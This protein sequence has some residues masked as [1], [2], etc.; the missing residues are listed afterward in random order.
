MTGK[1]P[2]DPFDLP[3]SDDL[4]DMIAAPLSEV[5]RDMG[6]LPTTNHS[7]VDAEA[8]G[9]NREH[10]YKEA[11]PKCRGTGRWYSY[12]GMT[13]QCFACK[14]EGFKYFK[15]SAEERARV[16][17][18]VEARKLSKV[19]KAVEAFKAEHPDIWAWMDGNTFEFAV[20]MAD[21]VRK[22]GS[23]TPGQLDACRRSIAKRA[24]AKAAAAAR[25]EN[26]P[27][28][29]LTKLSLA[30]ESARS[31]GLKRI[32]V[33]FAGLE[34]TEAP[35]HGKN[36]GSLYV[37]ADGE[38]VGKI[39]SGRFLCTRECNDATKERVLASMADPKAAAIA[40][41]KETGSCSCCG[42]ELSNPESIALG[43]GP[44]CAG[45]FGWA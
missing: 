17:A 1:N 9:V 10:A 21:A 8:Y 30:F 7:K 16:R 12:S 35:A 33:R 45:K 13:G 6:R 32:K 43:I 41:G 27:T 20:K 22:W 5:P 36:A 19:E 26:A 14:G 2:H 23:L 34:V 28:V 42:R 31:N 24:E 15:H 3:Q 39:T 25:V 37:K 4:S 11:C 38:Y 18:Q 44:I 29:D 40:Y